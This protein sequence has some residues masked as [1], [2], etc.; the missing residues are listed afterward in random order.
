MMRHLIRAN[1]LATLRNPLALIYGWLFPLIFL[2]GFWAIYA[3]DPLP[4]ALHAGQF[5]T[6]TILGSAA[7]GLPTQMVAEREAGLW[8]LYALTPAS[9]WRFVVA[10]VLARALLLAGALLLQH[11][12]ARLLGMPPLP[13]PV[14]TVLAL[15]TASLCFLCL[16]GLIGTLVANVP[17]V[18]ALGQCIFLPMLI[19]GGVAVP[20]ASLPDWALPVSNLLPG[21]HAVVAIQTAVT[22][23]GTR[24]AGFELALLAGHGAL[25]LLAAVLLFRWEPGQRLRPGWWLAA[26]AAAWLALAGLA[27]SRARP[28]PAPPDTAAAGV[29]ADYVRAAGVAVPPAAAPAPPAAMAPPRVV[30]APMPPAITAPV[31][32]APVAL[33]APDL[34]AIAFE[35]LPPD[36]GLVA[37]I[38]AEPP[39]AALAS[40]LARIERQVAG[41]PPAGEGDAVQQ[42]RSLL[43]IAAVPDLLQMDPLERHLPLLVQALL[44]QRFGAAL[45]SLLAQIA[46]HPDAGSLAARSQL[47]ALGLPA[48]TGA[49]GPLRGRVMLYAFKLLGR[50]TGRRMGDPPPP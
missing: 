19:I 38:A 34:D 40:A 7:F 5:F 36:A 3:R 30:T 44:E 46:L 25:A 33:P 28:V 24:A 4:L 17:A 11:G 10:L 15:I 22:G 45:P 13:H 42:V 16:G 9:R 31:A 35:R 39:D 1:L 32:P 12:A 8:R 47:P 18:Q 41:W 6:I 27:H 20:L 50:V 49:Q 23:T 21:R 43:L 37:P 14:S 26:I 48:H 2:A 29:V